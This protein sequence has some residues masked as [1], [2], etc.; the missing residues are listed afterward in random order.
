MEN[1]THIRIELGISAQKYIQQM[2]I[3]NELIEKQITKGIELA[4]NDLLIEDNFVQNVREMTKLELRN[5]VN[6]AVLS[7]EVKNKISKLVE[8][9]IGKK[10]ETFADGIAEKVTQSLK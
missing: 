10:I 3:N 5:I 4:L 8:E 1:L 7:W 2:Q 9:K 6:K